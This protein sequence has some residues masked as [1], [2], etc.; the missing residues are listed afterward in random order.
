MR[1][2]IDLIPR[3]RVTVSPSILAADFAALGSEVDKVTE[4][5]CDLLHLD[6]MD[7]HFVPNLT[8]GPP[9]LKSL[10]GRSDLIFD[11]H[12][13]LSDP[14]KYAEDFVKAGADHITFHLESDNNPDEVID[15]LRALGCT[16][17]ISLKPATPASAVIPYLNKIDLVLIMTVEPGFGG[18]S[19]M[20]DMMPKVK[21]VHEAIKAGN[22]PVHLEIDGGIDAKTVEVATKAGANMMVAGTSVFR[23]PAGTKVAI[24]Q[25]H[26]ATQ[27]L[28]L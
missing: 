27:W 12:L 28:K 19:F 6:V 15:A 2:I 4:A 14:L 17:G 21:E 20:A 23:N 26:A 8:M 11:T 10:R 7:G 3:D 13:M 22:L 5:G 24:E 9:L 16:V 25:L 18:Q 1:N